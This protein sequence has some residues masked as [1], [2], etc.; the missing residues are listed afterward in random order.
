MHAG[1]GIFKSHEVNALET[2]GNE[3]FILRMLQSLPIENFLIFFHLLGIFIILN[4]VCLASLQKS[5]T[6][7][8][9]TKNTSK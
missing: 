2:N 1:N 3:I 5:M 9:A 6:A 4:I 7:I 8:N